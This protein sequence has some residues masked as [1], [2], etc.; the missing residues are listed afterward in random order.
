MM[1]NNRVDFFF[2]LGIHNLSINNVERFYFNKEKES[3]H[4]G[5]SLRLT[6]LTVRPWQIT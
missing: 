4:M 2:E 1:I 5:V 3:G 6:P